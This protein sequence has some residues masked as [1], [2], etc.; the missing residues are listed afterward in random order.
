MSG[1]DTDDTIAAIASAPGASIRGIVRISGPGTLSCLCSVF[2]VNEGERSVE[3]LIADSPNPIHVS[4]SIELPIEIDAGQ[5]NDHASAA[6]E[7]SETVATDLLFWPTSKSYTRQPTAEF[8][9][10]G[11]T[12]ILQMVLSAVCKSGARLARP[13]EFTMRAFLSGRIDLTQAEAVLAV[14]DSNGQEQ[15]NTALAQLAGGLAGPLGE[16]RNQLMSVLAELE[17]GLDFVE[18][19]I[20]F[21]TEEDLTRDLSETKLDLERIKGQIL[22][23]DLIGETVKV[24]LVGMPNS[25]KSSLFNELAGSNKAIVTQVEGTTTDFISMELEIES[26]QIELIDTAGF[27][28]T[29]DRIAQQAQSHRE[30]QQQQAQVRLMCIDS[31]RPISSWESEQL[32]LSR[33]DEASLVVLTK[34]DLVSEEAIGSRTLEIQSSGLKGHVISTSSLTKTGIQRLRRQ[35]SLSVLD[36][37][38]S[39]ATVVGTTVL[40]AAESLREACESVEHALQAVR[41]RIGEEVVAAEIRQALEGLGHVVGTIYTDDILDLVFGRFCIG[42]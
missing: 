3:A 42:K 14:I 31:S 8:H 30:Q 9:L 6:S 25:G 33:H 15:L 29:D 20:E 17:A 32:E 5:P 40:R 7:T 11:S 13:G 41:D 34:S 27:E 22:E 36:A 23:R 18:E 2:S 10:I 19:D 16:I 39:D 35:I 38:T 24:V 26:A 21:I 1:F 37:N 12:P 28:L 4:G